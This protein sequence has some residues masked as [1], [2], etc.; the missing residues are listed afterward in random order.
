MKKLSLVILTSFLL[1]ACGAYKYLDLGMLTT[2]MT[3]AEVENLMGPP[4]RVLA[5]NKKDG[6]VQEVLEYRT[7][8]NEVYALEFWDNYLTG[9]EYLYDNVNYLPP[10]APPM[11]FPDYGRP[12]YIYPPDHHPSHP[13]RPNKPNRPNRPSRPESNRP[14]RPESN[15]PESNRPESNRPG[16]PETSRPQTKPSE[17][18]RPSNSGTSNRTEQYTNPTNSQ[19]KTNDRSNTSGRNGGR[20]Q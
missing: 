18:T 3:I 20:R 11:V 7:G 10:A 16:R 15:R 19:S 4:E 17:V 13:N 1:V 8:R 5:V 6:Y 12:I 2:G 14:S 9:Y